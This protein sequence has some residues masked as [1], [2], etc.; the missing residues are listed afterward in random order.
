MVKNISDFPPCGKMVVFVTEFVTFLKTSK[1]I[2]LEENGFGTENFKNIFL[3]NF[4]TS[5]LGQ[6]L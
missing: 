5:C 4:S 6:K 1:Y 3:D 2:E